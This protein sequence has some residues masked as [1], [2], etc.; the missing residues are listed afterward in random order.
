V[1][2][3]VR[4]TDVWGGPIDRRY[5]VLLLEGVVEVTNAAGSVVLRTPGEGTNIAA[6]GT[7]PGAV[8]RWPGDKVARAL[9]TVSFR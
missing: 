8:T 4:G 7:A 6:P 3:G 9:A 1:T 2:L 5:G